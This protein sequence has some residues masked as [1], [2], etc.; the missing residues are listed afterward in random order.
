MPNAAPAPAPPILPVA[1]EISLLTSADPLPAEV[2]SYDRWRSGLAA[3][4]LHTMTGG[5]WE[6]DCVVETDKS[7]IQEESISEFV[8]V[9]VYTHHGCN[10]RVDA[11]EYRSEATAV[12][13]AK[14]AFA[15]GSE[16][17]TGSVTGNPSLQSTAV[18]I[19]AFL[20]SQPVGVG[21]SALTEAFSQASAG[22]MGT[23]HVPYTVL[24]ELT[25]NNLVVR[26]G[27]RLETIIG[28]TVIPGPG[29]PSTTNT[30]PTDSEEPA[31]GTYYIYI[32]GPV[33]VGLGPTIVTGTQ[34][35]SVGDYARQNLVEFYAERQAIYRFPTTPVFALPVTAITFGG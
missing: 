3:R 22:T 34:T 6:V 24:H 19:G 20:G 30:A 4:E 18:D 13:E 14:L 21:F 26:K 17:W 27:N 8:P 33:Q 29:Y 15:L 2:A 16:L 10:G 23:I 5:L 32:T 28:Q 1:P 9:A 25:L 12:L 31:A 7:G 11:D 35:D